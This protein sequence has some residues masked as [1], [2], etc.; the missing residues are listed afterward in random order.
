VHATL[1][2]SQGVASRDVTAGLMSAVEQLLESRLHA[3]IWLDLV[4]QVVEAQVGVV[5]F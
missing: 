4:F 2:G 3:C 1:A 5:V